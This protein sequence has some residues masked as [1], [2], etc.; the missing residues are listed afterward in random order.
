M[1]G[2]M[3]ALRLAL[4]LGLGDVLGL[5]VVQSGGDGLLGEQRA[6]SLHRRQ[7]QVRGDI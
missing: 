4:S 1:T 3:A 7:L 5:E 6:V 2:K